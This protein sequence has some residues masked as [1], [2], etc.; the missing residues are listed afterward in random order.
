M[1]TQQHPSK[2]LV[3]V[4]ERGNLEQTHIASKDVPTPESLA[5][6][7]VLLA[8]DSFALTANN[9]TY[10]VFGEAMG[11]W[12]FFPAAPGEGRIPVWGFADVVHSANPELRAGERIFGYF[13]MST[14]YVL[15]ARA[16]TPAGF[17]DAAAHRQ[18]L[19]AV[20]NHYVRTAADPGYDDAR[21]SEQ[22]LFRPLFTTAFL[23][24]DFLADSD[25]FGASS[26]ILSSASSK[27]SIS[28][29]HGLSLR[30][31]CRVIGLTSPANADFVKGLGSY[32]EV[33]TYDDMESLPQDPAVFVDMAG[34]ARVVG[35]LHQH[36]AQALKYSCR[37]GGT[38]WTEISMDAELPG[39]PPV[40]FFAPDRI[41]QRSSD[42]GAAGLQARVAEAWNGFIP[43][44][45]S[46]MQVS[47]ARGP[48]AL[49]STYLEV[50]QG[51]ADP[52]V[53]HIVSMFE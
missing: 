45:D 37:V 50:L 31:G 41:A 23:I 39:P 25:F 38:H 20:Y 12:D 4:V 8:V 9:I 26:V 16:A 53:G 47:T 43:T 3:F 44:L 13:P 6:G 34:N 19:H 49:R 14:H 11:Y 30:D 33:V 32:D 42:W 2:A 36:F 40:M 17:D 1:P 22:M 28:L 18:H 46:W 35:R 48:E 27:T 52:R 5:D 21:E 29:A 51:R 7:Q 10:A 24:D 15:E